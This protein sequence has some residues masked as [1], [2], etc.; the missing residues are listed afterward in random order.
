MA[1][2]TIQITSVCAGGDHA[3]VRLTKGANVRNIPMAINELRA[4][5]TQNDIE[6]FCKVALQL[7]GEDKTLAQFKST[8]QSGFT[9]S[10]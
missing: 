6:S 3:S 7:M 2:I 1:S 10:L 4:N 9:I 5:L 8:A